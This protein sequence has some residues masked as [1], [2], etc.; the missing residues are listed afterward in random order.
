M[1]NSD[2][3]FT[4]WDT[5]NFSED[6]VNLNITQAL[7]IKDASGS[8]QN[9]SEGSIINTSS[10]QSV[11][12]KLFVQGAGVFGTGTSSSKAVFIGAE[13]TSSGGDLK[14]QPGSV[15]IDNSLSVGA[16][17]FIKDGVIDHLVVT[18]TNFQLVKTQAI[19]VTNNITTEGA[20]S[21][22]QTAN[23]K[24]LLVEEKLD[25]FDNLIMDKNAANDYRIKVKGTNLLIENGMLVADEIKINN[26]L[27]NS[28][29]ANNVYFKNSVGIE[30]DLTV[31][32]TLNLPNGVT[33]DDVSTVNKLTVG[34]TDADAELI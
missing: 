14:F 17:A 33:Y 12:L 30:G 3:N 15:I 19:S 5:R 7:L 6:I 18:E 8:F 11:A 13:K 10:E 32:G 28:T 21:V 1:A 29:T 26:V 2:K 4:L 25:V 20:L 22:H 34:S 24:D 31:T 9:P 23:L 16:T 27:L